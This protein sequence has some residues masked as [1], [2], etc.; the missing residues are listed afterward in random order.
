MPSLITM[1]CDVCDTQGKLTTQ[2]RVYVL[3]DGSTLPVFAAP[4]WCHSC[5]ALVEAEVLPV[6][7][8][9]ESTGLS[10]L[11][12]T[13]WRTWRNARKSKPRCFACGAPGVQLPPDVSFLKHLADQDAMGFE[14]PGCSGWFR[15]K[16][17]G[18]AMGKKDPKR[19]SPEGLPL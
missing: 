18:L 2:S 1:A 6:P 19:L 4:A 8:A 11:E 12:L 13:K 17:V 5:K 3:A 15:V 14:H 10:G 16:S 7:E 9:V